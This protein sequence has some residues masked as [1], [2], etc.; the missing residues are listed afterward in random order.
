MDNFGSIWFNSEK[1]WFGFGLEMLKLNLT[2]F[3]LIC[4]N[5][6]PKTKLTPLFTAM[7][8]LYIRHN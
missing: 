1:F 2:W 7:E 8:H 5:T 6:E 3:D 4:L